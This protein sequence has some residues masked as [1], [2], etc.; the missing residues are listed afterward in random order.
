MSKEKKELKF[1]FL[2]MYE[3]RAIRKTIEKLQKYIIDF[4]NA[5]VFILCQR[6][7]PDDDERIKLFNKNVIYSRLYDK[8]NPEEYF[9]KDSN[10]F[11]NTGQ[12]NWKSPGNCQV[13]INNYEYY[14]IMKNYYQNYDYFICMRVD[15]DI[16]FDFPD[17]E[18]FQIIPNDIYSFNPEYARQW[19]GSGGGNF[20]HRDFI[21]DYLSSYWN[22]LTNSNHRQL[23]INYANN[24]HILNQEKML[25]LALKVKDISMYFINNINYYYTAETLNDYTTFADIKM[26]PEYKVI[27]KYK[28]QVDEAFCTLNFWKSG[29]IWSFINE[30]IKLN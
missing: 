12:G 14:K 10:F 25:E 22:L 28:K 17:K 2:V 27:Y 5:D 23:L 11:I 9:S 26:H 6:Q 13:Y 30:T 18:L 15:I 16:L 24:S 29:K 8:P 7:F 3:L 20:V 1:A 4:Y 21:L 19:S